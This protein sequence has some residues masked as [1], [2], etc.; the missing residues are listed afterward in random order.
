MSQSKI[1]ILLA[2]A[3]VTD[4]AGAAHLT[5]ERVATVAQLSKGGLLYHYPNKRALLEGMLL[6]L[7]EQTE[8]RL[9]HH[10]RTL[11]ESARRPIAESLVLTASEQSTTERTLSQVLLAAA[12]ED[13]ELL[14]PAR[15]VIQ[16][17][18]HEVREEDSA[19]LLLVLALEGLR[20][21]TLLNLLPDPEADSAEL[22]ALL[23][24]AVRQP[25]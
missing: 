12:A 6:Y 2:A 13:P 19:G 25:L 22:Y 8:E 9:A 11:R 20:F 24:Q 5:L 15:T 18:L 4:R 1:K 3:Q 17:W 7:L 10:R 16:R 14:E 21:L 23:H